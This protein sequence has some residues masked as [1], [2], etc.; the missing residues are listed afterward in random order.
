MG[1]VTNQRAAFGP[2]GTNGPIREQENFGAKKRRQGTTKDFL[3]FIFP[4]S[5]SETP[6][7][8]FGPFLGRSSANLAKKKEMSLRG[9]EPGTSG[10]ATPRDHRGTTASHTQQD[11]KNLGTYL[12]TGRKPARISVKILERKE[13]FI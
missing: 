7:N 1:S 9:L 8:P 4:F 6:R 3:I 2:R 12:A 13:E 10:V 5:P 11:R